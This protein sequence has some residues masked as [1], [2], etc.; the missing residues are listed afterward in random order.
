[1]CGKLNDFEKRPT[2]SASVLFHSKYIQKPITILLRTVTLSSDAVSF[3]SATICC[4]LFTYLPE[5][6]NERRG[7]VS[8]WY[9]TGG[10]MFWTVTW[11]EWGWWWQQDV[12]ESLF[13][14]THSHDIKSNVCALPR[15][16]R[17]SYLYRVLKDF[18]SAVQ[19]YRNYGQLLYVYITRILHTELYMCTMYILYVLYI[20][21]TREKFE[22]TFC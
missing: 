14:F 3:S 9:F 8:E 18:Q 11:F 6:W 19:L 5:T 4:T 15:H 1:M 10:R 21:S 20:F 7:H 12:A 22:R 13:L 2:I 17:I 16:A